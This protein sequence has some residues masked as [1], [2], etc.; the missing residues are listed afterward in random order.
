MVGLAQQGIIQMVL[1]NTFSFKCSLIILTRSYVCATSNYCSFCYFSSSSKCK[2]LF[3]PKF[4]AVYSQLLSKELGVPND[5]MPTSGSLLQ[6]LLLGLIIPVVASIQP[7]RA[8]LSKN[9]GDSL[10]YQRS[11]N[12]SVYLEVL[13]SEQNGKKTSIIFGILTVI[14]GLTIYYFLPLSILELD[15]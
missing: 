15:L 4:Q 5:P 10:D 6:A 13:S 12:Q 8:S 7:I 3:N 9:L 2:I 11:K 14:Y 1:I